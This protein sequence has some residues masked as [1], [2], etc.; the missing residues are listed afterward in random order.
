LGRR[1]GRALRGPASFGQELREA[2][3]DLFGAAVHKQATADRNLIADLQHAHLDRMTINPRTVG[4]LEIRQDQLAAI[5]LNL[6]VKTADAFV[7]QADAVFVLA[8]ERDGSVQLSKDQAAFE[9]FEQL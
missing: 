4:A 1:F 7:I 3:A 9:P 2:A 5:F 6:R 8:A